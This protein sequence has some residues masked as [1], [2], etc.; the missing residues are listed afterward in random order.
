MVT[1]IN[2]S[3]I[4]VVV[5]LYKE[6]SETPC[7][8]FIEE[9]FM[10]A[11]TS[12][13]NQTTPQAFIYLGDCYNNFYSLPLLCPHLLI[14]SSSLDEVLLR[15]AKIIEHTHVLA[16]VTYIKYIAVLRMM[17]RERKRK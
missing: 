17:V 3:V 5:G 1:N 8:E 16:A 10:H 6:G 9:A 15:Y 14:L 4:S 7:D 12:T 13:I 11:T 2:S